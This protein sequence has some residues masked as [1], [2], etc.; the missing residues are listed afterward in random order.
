MA[1]TDIQPDKSTG[2]VVALCG[3][4]GGAKLALGLSRVLPDERLLI[5]VNTGDDF[6]HLGL[7]V[8]PDIDTVT[9]TLAGVSNPE[10]GWGRAD[11]T[12]NFMEALG[13]I[14]GETWFSLGDKDLAVNVERTHRLHSGESLSAITRDICRNLGI[15]VQ[16]V[17]MSDDPVRTLV[18]TDA[19]PLPFQK[20]FVERQCVPVLRSVV[21]AGA[22]NASVQP[23]LLAALQQRDLRAVIIC[24]SNPY[25]SV[26]PILSV[27]GMREALQSVSA[28][29]VAVSPV[30]GG[31]AV[32]GPMAKIM[33]ELGLTV[34]HGTIAKH[35]AELIDG[36]MIDGDSERITGKLAVMT[37]NTIMKSLEDKISLARGVLTFAD[38][39]A[40]GCNNLRGQRA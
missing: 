36:L 40:A 30:V 15:P 38:Q 23:E 39:F 17:P 20:Y 1:P 37:G 8:S 33:G 34:T 25:L 24:P 4:I 35:Y 21:F 11:E 2:S 19:G 32:K 5:G 16:I 6:E 7:H 13:E 28:P 31:D 27:N 29:I 22:D 14:G 10:M 12:W 18:D 9:Y 26:D 3:G